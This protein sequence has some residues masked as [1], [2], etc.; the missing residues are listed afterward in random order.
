MKKHLLKLSITVIS[1]VYLLSMP[2][3]AQAA[4]VEYES[5]SNS[6]NGEFTDVQADAWFAEDLRFMVNEGIINGYEDG[7]FRP[8][9]SVT[10]GAILKMLCI[11][12]GSGELTSQSG[13][14]W[15]QAY[16]DYAYS[17]NWLKAPENDLDAPA[18]RIFVANLIFESMRMTPDPRIATPFADIDFP[19]LNTLYEMGIISG[20]VNEANQ[21]VFK[22]ED[23]ISRAETAVILGNVSEYFAEDFGV[24]D[25]RYQLPS[26]AK[27][28]ISSTPDIYNYVDL[29]TYMMVHDI[30]E[31]EL[32]YTIP[33]GN[34][35][36]VVMN[37]Y[38]LR[39]IMFDAFVFVQDHYHEIGGF[40]ITISDSI[41][42]DDTQVTVTVTIGNDKIASSQEQHASLKENFILAA[43]DYMTLLFELGIV[44]HDMSQ[45]ELAEN[46]YR[47]LAFDYAYDTSYSDIN[48]NGYGMFSNHV[49]VCQA[50]V[51]I[52]NI[53][54][55]MTGIDAYGVSGVAGGEDHI[56]SYIT[57]DGINTFV[58]PTWGDPTPDTH[59]YYDPNW[60]GLS[61]T[62]LSATHQFDDIYNGKI[63]NIT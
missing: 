59:G 4:P 43:Q 62:Q 37:D 8:S 61:R 50:Y 5:I 27:P 26:I 25:F 19:V 1:L 18:S 54:C 32:S 42:Y 17:Y 24:T 11:H 48:Y 3:W 44:N 52:F 39:G 9:D 10:K 31:Y 14:H 57:I 35:Y 28:V 12:R 36:N 58:D 41:T 45:T 6:T 23:S 2:T 47:Q 63:I 60:F 40:Y 30:Y 55:K 34:A 56:W 33:S 53:L 20:S 21:V 7:T 22:A 15:A 51:G 49:G 16:S 46:Y 38:D 13:Q 29:F